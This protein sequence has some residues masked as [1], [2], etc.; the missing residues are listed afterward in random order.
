MPLDETTAIKMQSGTNK[1][2]ERYIQDYLSKI[3][4]FQYYM[5]TKENTIDLYVPFEEKGSLIGKWGDNIR[6]LEKDLT[7]RISVKT[8]D[9]L[10]E[11]HQFQS[12]K[13]KFMFKKKKKLCK[14]CPNR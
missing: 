3:V 6:T 9:D 12:I 1:L 2:A 5:D 11:W 14:K 8:F 10:P 13:P 7:M 4:Q